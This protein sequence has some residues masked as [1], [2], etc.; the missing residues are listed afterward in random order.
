MGWAA[1]RWADRARGF[2]PACH[3]FSCSPTPQSGTKAYEVMTG[4][5]L[6]SCRRRPGTSRA[7]RTPRRIASRSG[8]RW[9][10]CNDSLGPGLARRRDVGA[11]C[12]PVAGTL[13]RR[14]SVAARTRPCA[15]RDPGRHE[16]G[17]VRAAP[18]VGGLP[19]N[20]ASSL[21]RPAARHVL[22]AGSAGR[23]SVT[24]AS[25]DDPGSGWALQP[26]NRGEEA[27]T[28][29]TGRA[30]P[31]FGFADAEGDRAGAGPL[32]STCTDGGFR[33]RRRAGRR[34]GAPLHRRRLPAAASS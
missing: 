8:R 6:F 29:P 21:P 13:G 31:M 18:K 2:S 32:V 5:S 12:R 11:W 19:D 20:D 34:P 27:A 7:S 24:G 4:G 15:R 22:A 1:S 33:A 9:P 17:A 10:T 16:V 26:M 23:P 14:F 28:R 3:I 30:T 25:K